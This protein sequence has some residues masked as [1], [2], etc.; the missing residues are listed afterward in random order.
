CDDGA[1]RAAEVMIAAVLAK[2][3]RG[4]EAVAVRLT[5]LAHPAVESRIGAK[6]GSLR[7][8]AALN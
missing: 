6:V 4:D 3:L 1:G 2:L 7:P 8:T 5:Q